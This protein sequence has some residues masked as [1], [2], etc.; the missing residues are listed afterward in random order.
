M[1]QFEASCLAAV[2]DLAVLFAYEPDEPVARSLVQMRT[3]LVDQFCRA[4]PNYHERDITTGVDGL[5]KQIQIRRREIE[6]GGRSLD[7]IA[8]S[9]SWR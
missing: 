4:F 8:I 6:A 9:V 5:I 3:N 1:N 2:N 7:R